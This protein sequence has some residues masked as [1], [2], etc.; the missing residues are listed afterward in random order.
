[1]PPLSP[2]ASPA[3]CLAKRRTYSVLCIEM[4]SQRHSEIFLKDD[5][6][7]SGLVEAC[8]TTLGTATSLQKAYI[9]H[10]TCS[11]DHS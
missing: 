2:L 1:M 11:S 9:T 3:R 5:D 6:W 7:I 10:S 8:V 4:A